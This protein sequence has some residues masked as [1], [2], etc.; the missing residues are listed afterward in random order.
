MPVP[1]PTATSLAG[2]VATPSGV[3]ARLQADQ[4]RILAL[5][6]RYQLREDD[7]HNGLVCSRCCAQLTVHLL[8]TEALLHP[9]ARQRLD[10]DAWLDDAEVAANVIRLAIA[11]LH[12]DDVRIRHRDALFATL[13][14]YTG[15]HFAEADQQLYAPLAALA[16][17]TT[18]LARAVD[19]QQRQLA[20][21]FG[22]AA[23]LPVEPCEALRR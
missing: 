2:I 10:A 4:R 11:L 23:E 14:E 1:R 22:Q 16:P 3:L 13:A 17:D 15:S 9:F 20:R 12:G 19:A 7:E 8:I 18:D 5:A 21:W 6:A